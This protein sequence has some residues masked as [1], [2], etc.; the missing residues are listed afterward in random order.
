MNSMNIK[1]KKVLTIIIIVL[2]TIAMG[3]VFKY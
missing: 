2:K 1:A 3:K